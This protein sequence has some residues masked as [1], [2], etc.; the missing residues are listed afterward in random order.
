MLFNFADLF[1]E[2]PFFVTHSIS[3]T[4]T[5][6]PGGNNTNK[7]NYRPISFMNIKL[8]LEQ[9]GF[10]LHRSTYMR[11]F[12]NKSYSTTWSASGWIH[13]C[14]TMD[15][16]G[17]LWDLSLHGSWYL[18]QVLRSVPCGYRGMTVDTVVLNKMLKNGIQQNIKRIINHDW[19]GFIPGLLGW[20]KI[21]KS[22]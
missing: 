15:S 12:F 1:K 13:E 17:Q 2:S 7:V 9:C 18:Q 19:V 11:I 6:K 20:S 22:K 14:S 5:P 4:L 21:W 8:T 10:E 16:E 3:I